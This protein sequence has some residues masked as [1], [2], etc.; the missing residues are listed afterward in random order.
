MSGYT[1]EFETTSHSYNPT[2]GI[3]SLEPSAPI[4][5]PQG[6]A[7]AIW[8]LSFSNAVSHKDRIVQVWTWTRTLPTPKNVRVDDDGKE[9]VDISKPA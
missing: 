3:G 1:Y 2:E 6:N 8:F 9:Y 5:P 4:V 7:K